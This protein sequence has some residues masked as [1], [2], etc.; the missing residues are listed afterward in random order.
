MLF[1]GGNKISTKNSTVN[2]ILALNTTLKEEDNRYV[3]SNKWLVYHLVMIFVTFLLPTIFA[4]E[5]HSI[6]EDNGLGLNIGRIIWWVSLIFVY[7]WSIIVQKIYPQQD[8]G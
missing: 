5:K 8:L 4:Y 2:Q 7:T 1:Q 6:P 3:S